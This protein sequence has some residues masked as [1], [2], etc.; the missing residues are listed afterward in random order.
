MPSYDYRCLNENCSVDIFEVSQKITEDPLKECI[1]C[2]GEVKRI[3]TKNLG[4]INKSGGFY[5]NSNV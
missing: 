5:K 1:K 2:G 4:F 3:I